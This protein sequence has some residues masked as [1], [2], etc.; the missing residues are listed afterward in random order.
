[1]N[2]EAWLKLYNY[3]RGVPTVT[4]ADARRF[5]DEQYNELKDAERYPAGSK[6]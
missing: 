1:M 4:D 2:N 6:A 5:A 3:W